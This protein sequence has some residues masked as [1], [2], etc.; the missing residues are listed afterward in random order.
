MSGLGEEDYAAD[1]MPR[2]DYIR[3]SSGAPQVNFGDGKMTQCA[4]SSSHGD[5]LEDRSALTNWRIDKAMDGVAARKEIAAKVIAAGDD[6]SARIDLREEAIS[7]GRGSFKAD[8]GTAFHLMA[9]R[10]EEE[11]DFDPP[12][13]FAKALRAY[14]AG[15]EVLGLRT[16]MVECTF[17]N[18]EPKTAGSADRLYELTAD[19]TT[20][21]GL[22]MPAGT[23]IIGD[24]KTG[25]KLEYSIPGYAVQ[26]YLYA[27]GQLYDVVNNVPLP[28]P[29]INQR[30]GVISHVNIEEG[31]CEFLWVDLH[32]GRIG[33]EI[34]SAV[35]EWRRCWNR[36]PG[37]AAGESF[38]DTSLVAV[39][40][41]GVERSVAELG[42]QLLAEP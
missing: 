16:Q 14:E 27:S 5:V 36:K 37:S 11:P 23:L 6:R 30:W 9:D 8:I 1:A 39:R 19:L 17:F 20:P 34:A 2:P 4:R 18:T 21:D 7:A 15:M 35:K 12:E 41:P 31:T 38:K 32:T 22:T 13:E 25:S 42:R 3:G 28:T 29:P 26:L 10:W 40:E 33:A 24:M